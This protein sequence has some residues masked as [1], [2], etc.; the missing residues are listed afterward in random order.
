MVNVSLCKSCRQGSPF[1]WWW[2]CWVRGDCDITHKLATPGQCWWHLPTGALTGWLLGDHILLLVKDNGSCREGSGAVP[3]PPE[4]FSL[5][6]W[7]QWAL[8]SWGAFHPSDVVTSHRVCLPRRT[9]VKMPPH[10]FQRQ[11]GNN[12]HEEVDGS[13]AVMMKCEVFLFA[14]NSGSSSCTKSLVVTLKI[15]R[16]GSCDSV[17]VRTESSNLKPKHL[18]YTSELLISLR[19]LGVGRRLGKTGGEP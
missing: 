10:P 14:L 4:C 13:R 1:Q 6:S 18:A 19:K 12:E 11:V 8:L 7:R 2:H 15:I 9:I 17:P 5:V 3:A 16:C